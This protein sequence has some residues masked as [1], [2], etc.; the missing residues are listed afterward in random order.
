ME[1]RLQS[2]LGVITDNVA[3]QN[4]TNITAA[5]TARVYSHFRRNPAKSFSWKGWGG[6]EGP[7]KVTGRTIPPQLG[8]PGP[9]R[10]SEISVAQVPATKTQSPAEQSGGALYRLA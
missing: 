8:R 3:E 6:L 10:M 1:I 7:C 4:A 9:L 5:F 2:R